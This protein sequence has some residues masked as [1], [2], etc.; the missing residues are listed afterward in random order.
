MR[1]TT[2]RTRITTYDDDG[3]FRAVAADVVLD[4]HAV[5]PR[6]G[7]GRCGYSQADLVH[8]CIRGNLGN[9]YISKVINI[10]RTQ[11]IRTL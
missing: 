6:V 11:V 2:V 10:T 9:G 3:E 1:I 7:S 5:F 4:D 8:A